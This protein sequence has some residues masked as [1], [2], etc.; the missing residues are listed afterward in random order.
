MHKKNK[1]L[2]NNYFKIALKDPKN[3]KKCSKFEELMFSVLFWG[4]FC[5]IWYLEKKFFDWY[6]FD[7]KAILKCYLFVLSHLIK[8]YLILDFENHLPNKKVWFWCKN[9]SQNS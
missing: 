7:K 3:K 2:M 1:K 6:L 8:C 4:F 5:R 9:Q